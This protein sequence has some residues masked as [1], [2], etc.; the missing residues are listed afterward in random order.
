MLKTS[1][2]TDSLTSATQFTI[3]YDRV[4]GDGGKLVKK[5]QK[6]EK[7]SKVKKPQRPDKSAKT[8]GSE[9]SCFLTSNTRL[10]LIKIDKSHN[11]ELSTLLEAFKN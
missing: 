10:A 11:R 8:I 2:S 5:S 7:L 4:N 9:K 6:V 1:S 3:K